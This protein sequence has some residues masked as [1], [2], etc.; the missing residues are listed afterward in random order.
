M[1]KMSYPMDY[2]NDWMYEPVLE[3]DCGNSLHP[4]DQLNER[5]YDDLAYIPSSATCS[6]P[7]ADVSHGTS[8]RL[9]AAIGANADV[10]DSSSSGCNESN[11]C[12]ALQEMI[13]RP[14]SPTLKSRLR[15]N[16]RAVIPKAPAAPSR[17]EGSS[18]PGRPVV[19][20]TQRTVVTEKGKVGRQQVK[21][22]KYT[23]QDLVRESQT[24]G[25]NV[26]P[27]ISSFL[28]DPDGMDFVQSTIGSS[29]DSWL[30]VARHIASLLRHECLSGAMSKMAASLM[31]VDMWM[32]EISIECKNALANETGVA[33]L[34]P[35]AHCVIVELSARALL[36]EESVRS[37]LHSIWTKDNAKCVTEVLRYLLHV[38][39]PGGTDPGTN[40]YSPG[41][42]ILA[43]VMTE[44]SGTMPG[45]GNTCTQ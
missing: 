20:A 18:K 22:P 36:D 30:C 34:P 23:I 33:V 45:H 38:Y 4:E 27:F 39:K 21:S 28:M 15:Q 6:D 44:R 3:S 13:I 42:R 19:F 41:L 14:V 8:I 29:H 17:R 5:S 31:S 12:E 9:E 35:L 40:P 43:S 32:K 24:G 16:K 10:S 26:A 1:A 37:T 2:S 25:H 7:S 11:S